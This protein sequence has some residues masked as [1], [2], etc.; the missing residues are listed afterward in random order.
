[1]FRVK[2]RVRVMR[3]LHGRVPGPRDGDMSTVLYLCAGGFVCVG[4]GLDQG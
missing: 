4:G 1:M 3:M 2:V